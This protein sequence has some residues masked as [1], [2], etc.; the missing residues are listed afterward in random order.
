MTPEDEPKEAAPESVELKE[1]WDDLKEVLDLP[2]VSD[3]KLRE[4]VNDFLSNRIFTS[5]HVKDADV[6]LIPNI[7]LPLSFGCFSSLQP[8]SLDQIGCIY[9]YYEKSSPRS[10]NGYPIFLSFNL[11]HIDD[12]TRARAAIHREMER[13]ENIEL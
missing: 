8:A 4:F 6:E 12:W 2:R 9:E 3:D 7:F 11:L 10:L 1:H 5:A 13:R